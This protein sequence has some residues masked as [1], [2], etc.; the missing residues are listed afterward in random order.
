MEDP[1]YTISTEEFLSFLENDARLRVDDFIKGAVEVAQEVHSDVKR[2]DGHS[3]FLD[4][5]KWPVAA[6]VV[7]HYRSVNRN[8]TSVE[9]ASAI[10]HDILEDNDR[11][12]DLYKTKSY[13]F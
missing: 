5:H 10:L 6:D 12:L 3:S 11:I 7:R 8:I 1:T 9:V 4:T 13:G 2:E